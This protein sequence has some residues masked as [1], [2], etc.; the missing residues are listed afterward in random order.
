MLSHL[1]EHLRMSWRIL[2]KELTAFGAVG[3]VA[4]VVQ[5]GLFNLL[6]HRG[7]GPLTS[8]AVAVV[9][10]TAVAYIGNRYFSF[11]HRARTGL[12]RE[13]G[14]F[15]AINALTF[16]LAEVILATAYLFHA[17]K[18]RLVVNVLNIIG[19]GIGTVIRFWAYKR[20]VF[21]HPDRVHPLT[22]K[23]DVDDRAIVDERAA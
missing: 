9:A 7:V 12:G 3:F 22:G 10:A 18:D 4:F 21:L 14:F 11:S 19:I 8:N 16:L 1:V 15:F 5:L 20:F 17:E 2:L 13:A 23:I 6:V